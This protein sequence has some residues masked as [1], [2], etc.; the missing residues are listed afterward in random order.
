MERLTQSLNSGCPEIGWEDNLGVNQSRAIGTQRR[1]VYGNRTGR[2]SL[3]GARSGKAKVEIRMTSR[4]TKLPMLSEVQGWGGCQ[5][6]K[7]SPAMAHGWVRSC[8]MWQE[9]EVGALLSG[10]GGQ[11]R[12]TWN[13]CKGSWHGPQAD[14]V[15]SWA[16]TLQQAA[17]WGAMMAQRGPPE[18]SPTWVGSSHQ[19]PQHTLWAMLSE[20]VTSSKTGALNP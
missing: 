8:G 15:T 3:V 16:H 19:G 1:G 9:P 4:E 17:R 5:E 13:V 18:L 20:T 6:L 7:A 11:R 2:P 14:P 10:T 12:P